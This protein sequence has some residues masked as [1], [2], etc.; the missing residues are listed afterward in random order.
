MNKL[1]EIKSKMQEIATLKQG[2]VDQLKQDF[3][4]IVKPLFDKLPEVIKT[5]G[6]IQ[7]TPYFN[8]GD[9][10]RFSVHCDIDYGIRINRGYLDDLED[11]DGEDVKLFGSSLYAM[12][13]FGTDRYA[14]WVEKYPEDKINEE[15]KERDL[16]IYNTLK[17]FSD[18]IYSIDADI[19][20]DLF[21]DHSEIIVHRN[22]TVETEEYD[23]D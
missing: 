23:H 9:E 14:E 21:E 17:E 22:G 20:K 16:E 13:H 11:E 15:T 10:C 5:I 19:L 7:Y 12:R 1:E 6:W 3:F 4:P 2:L 8:D 18:L